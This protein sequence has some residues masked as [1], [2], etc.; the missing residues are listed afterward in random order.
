MV[1]LTIVILINE[2]RA[3]KDIFVSNGIP[4]IG[5]K[6]KK[7]HMVTAQQK[8]VTARKSLNNPC[9]RIL[10]ET[11]DGLLSTGLFSHRPNQAR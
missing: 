10:V 4:S 5:K 8:M 9:A 3:S 6:I 1:R 7:N 11:T 2:R